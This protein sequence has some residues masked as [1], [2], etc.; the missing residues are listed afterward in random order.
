MTIDLARAVQTTEKCGAL[1]NKEFS[2]QASLESSMDF[3]YIWPKKNWWLHFISDLQGEKGI[4]GDK[5][6]QGEKVS[7]WKMCIWL[8]RHLAEIS[9]YFKLSLNMK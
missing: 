8:N 9:M 4:R 5:G 6:D 7:L 2:F 1:L 3:I